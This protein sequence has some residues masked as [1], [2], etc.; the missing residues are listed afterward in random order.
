MDKANDMDL[1]IV[2]LKSA[3]LNKYRFLYLHKKVMQCPKC[4]TE[5][6]V[7]H[8]IVKGKQRYQCKSCKYTYTVRERGKSKEIKNKPYNFIWKD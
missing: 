6:Y 5:Q 3:L 8:G 4:K 2:N 1:N 7:K